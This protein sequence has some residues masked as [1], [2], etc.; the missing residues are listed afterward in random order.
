MY[1]MQYQPEKAVSFSDIKKSLF[2][3]EKKP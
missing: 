1:L 2:F 3:F